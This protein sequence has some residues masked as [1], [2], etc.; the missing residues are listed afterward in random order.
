MRR[1]D[2]LGRWRPDRLI[3]RLSDVLRLCS[4]HLGIV[5][6][7]SLAFD[8]GAVHGGLLRTLAIVAFAA[9]A[10]IAVAAA[11]L[12]RLALLLAGSTLF[13]AR[14]H[15]LTRIVLNR[16][17]HG[18]A[19]Q[20][21]GR[22]RAGAF[23]AFVAAFTAT[24]IAVTALAAAFATGFA[25]AAITAVALGAVS[26]GVAVLGGAVLAL[27]SALTHRSSHGRLIGECQVL[28]GRVARN[29]AI[30]TTVTAVATFAAV[31]TLT[32]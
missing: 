24:T 8:G 29:A 13:L 5:I 6:A 1:S 4:R 11:A 12:A 10:S 23:C 19:I 27:R 22:Y 31:T 14:H 9:V 25:W 28:F 16:R 15:D 21:I 26:V 2:G 7:A 30:T 20:C 32:T 3:S 18:F 17:D